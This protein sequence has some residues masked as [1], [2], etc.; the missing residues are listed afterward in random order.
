MLKLQEGKMSAYL[1]IIILLLVVVMVFAKLKSLLGTRPENETEISRESAA[2]IFDILMQEHNRKHGAQPTPAEL[3]TDDENLS[4][5]E[6]ALQKIPGFNRDKFLNSAKKAF[7]IIVTSFAKGDVKTLE[8][9]VSKNLLKKFKEIIGKRQEEGISAE[10]DFIGF[11]EG[12]VVKRRR[13]GYGKI[14][15]RY[16]DEVQRYVAERH[17]AVK[18]LLGVL[19]RHGFQLLRREHDAQRNHRRDQQYDGQNRQYQND[20]Q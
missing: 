9:L 1:D 2:K 5:S 11:D 18:R 15:Q 16:A 10:T 19:L 13:F 3:R 20:F 17:L 14:V 12:A 8:T 6:K 4:E 7:E